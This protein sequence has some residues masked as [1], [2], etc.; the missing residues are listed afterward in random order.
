M[1]LRRPNLLDAFRRMKENPAP[2][3]GGSA[4]VPTG[5]G[6]TGAGATPSTPQPGVSH[7]VPA[8]AAEDTG[9][10]RMP[11]GASPT[12]PVAGSG[13]PP[14]ARPEITTSADAPSSRVVPPSSRVVPPSSRVD[15]P[16]ARPAAPPKERLLLLAL[17][18][19]VAILVLV[20]MLRRDSTS[21]TAVQAGDGSTAIAE[22]PGPVTPTPAPIAN[23][24]ARLPHDAALHDAKNRYTVRLAQYPNDAQG[25]ALATE[26][27]RWLLKFGY[28]AG[29]PILLGS[30]KGIALVASAKPTR[31]ELVPLRDNLRRLRYPE[32]SKTMPFSDAY[33]DEIDDVLAR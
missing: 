31:E 20:M 29:S 4:S 16:A 9:P 33:I 15:P 12:S 23:S 22:Q 10:S 5:G 2:G 3:A 14:T 26:A 32:S 7:P 27:Y 21:P 18:I 13:I 11:A 8:R 28:P 1:P 24:P 19:T 17:G 6:A 25:V 30:G